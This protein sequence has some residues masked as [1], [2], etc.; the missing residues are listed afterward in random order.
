MSLLR[1]LRERNMPRPGEDVAIYQNNHLLAAGKV[2]AV[3]NS[4][5]TIAA[6]DGLVDLDTEQVRRGIHDGSIEIKREL[7]DL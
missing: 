3:D 2:I 6:D 7:A 5:V 1:R 4:T